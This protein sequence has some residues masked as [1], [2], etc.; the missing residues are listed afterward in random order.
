MDKSFENLDWSLVQAFLAVVE[1][2]SLS[3]AARN[4]GTSQPTLGRQIKQME[5]HLGLDLFQRQPRGLDL[6]ETG[7][8]LLAPAKQMRDAMNK[9][10]LTAAGRET[11]LHGTVRITASLA[12]AQYSL[13]PIIAKIREQEPDISIEVVPNDAA[14]NLLFREADIAVRMFRSTQLDVVTTHLG[15]LKLGLYGAKTYL[16]RVGRP[17]DFQDIFDLDW[18]GYDRSEMIIRG[19]RDAGY[20]VSR[21]WFKT[22]CDNQTVYWELIRNGCGLGFAQVHVAQSDPLVEEVITGLPIPGLPIWLAA[23]EAVR[24]TPRIS[25]VWDMLAAG[26]KPM[27]S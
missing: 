16:D 26:L 9:I 23:H 17:T 8:A 24:K 25:R 12:T 18:V 15:D 6:T 5:Q 22:R 27:L 4:L 10:A 1:T 21:E 19:M 20:E 14:D 2:G 7:Q 11:S 13:P 3:A